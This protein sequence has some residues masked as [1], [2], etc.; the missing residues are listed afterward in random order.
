MP[1]GNWL[2]PLTGTQTAWRPAREHALAKDLEFRWEGPWKRSPDRK[3]RARVVFRVDDDGWGRARIEVADGT[4][5]R[6]S[7]AFVCGNEV[8]LIRA[9]AKDLRWEGSDAVIHTLGGRGLRSPLER[10]RLHQQLQQI[11]VDYP[12]AAWG[13]V[14]VMFAHV[15]A[16]FEAIAPESSR[17]TLE[18]LGE[19]M[20]P[21]PAPVTDAPRPSVVE[22]DDPHP[23]QR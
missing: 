7:S 9:I 20:W 19:E 4:T 23:L 18:G 16:L 21:P 12:P 6:S 5:T 14:D 17:L 11:E 13:D 2:R 1:C 22:V 10:Q 3:H 8:R 15:G